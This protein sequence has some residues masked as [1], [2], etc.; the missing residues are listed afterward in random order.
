M[1]NRF[2]RTDNLPLAYGHTVGAV[3]GQTDNRLKFNISGTAGD[4][5]YVELRS[6]IPTSRTA[7]FALTAQDAGILNNMNAAASVI[8]TLPLAASCPGASFK[9]YVAQLPSSGAGVA[10]S[11]AAA[12]MIIGNGFTG[13][14]DKDA[15]CVVASDRVGD[16]IEVTSLGGTT[17]LITG[18]NGT[19]SREA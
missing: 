1:V 14:A 9:F 7:A 6:G 15:V 11:P 13:A 10:V 17:Y 16:Y 19:W 12:D 8:A 5:R 3:V 4:T 2:R 18:I